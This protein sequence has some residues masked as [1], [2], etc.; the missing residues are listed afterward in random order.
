MQCAIRAC[1]MIQATIGKKNFESKRRSAIKCGLPVDKAVLLAVCDVHKVFEVGYKIPP[2]WA[3]QAC[4]RQVCK[5]LERADSEV[6]ENCLSS[7]IQQVNHGGAVFAAEKK[8]YSFE[9]KLQR[10]G[11]NISSDVVNLPVSE[12]HLNAMPVEP[13]VVFVPHREALKVADLKKIDKVSADMNR[14]L[15]RMK[16]HFFLT[17]SYNQSGR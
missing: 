9:G 2:T 8:P 15:K 14:K 11:I 13:M 4:G 7:L 17:R 3:T 12:K 1:Y 16:D 10:V 5:A 6:A